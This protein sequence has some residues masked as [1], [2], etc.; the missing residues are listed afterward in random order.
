MNEQ[1]KIN[2]LDESLALNK[3]AIDLL[4]QKKKNHL[5]LWIIII[6][7]IV[8]NLAEVCIFIW[9]E[10]QMETVETVTTTTTVDQDTGEGTGNN[11][12]QAGEHAQYSEGGD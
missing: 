2:A 4:N 5:R 12:Y 11:V 3:I 7:L 6:A 10:S 8:V 1:E 9:Y